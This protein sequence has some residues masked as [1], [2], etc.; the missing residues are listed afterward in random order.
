MV[1]PNNTA[2]DWG[3]MNGIFGCIYIHSS[4]EHLKGTKSVIKKC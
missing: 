4:L 2:Y 3:E 1:Y